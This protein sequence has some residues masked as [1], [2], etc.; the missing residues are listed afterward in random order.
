[1]KHLSVQII[2]NIDSA[3]EVLRVK[4]PKSILF[5]KFVRS[6]TALT[7]TPPYFYAIAT[8]TLSITVYCV[9]KVNFFAFPNVF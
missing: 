3:Q 7:F 2:L 9:N 6:K 8:R 5:V 1:M 4:I